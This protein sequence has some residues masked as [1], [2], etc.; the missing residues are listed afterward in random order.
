MNTQNESM[1]ESMTMVRK[2]ARGELSVKARLGYVVLL[3][4]SS[5]MT[6]GLVS[7]WLTEAWLPLRTHLAFG[8]MSLIGI[9]WAALATWALTTRRVLFARDRVMAGRMS[10]A[11]TALFLAGSIAALL[12][13]G[14]AAAL[15]AAVTGAVMLVIALRV[16]AGARRR[17]DALASQRAELENQLAR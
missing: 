8:A 10:V 11:F 15:G 7:L 13:T 9:A 6:V 16:L 4:A 5:A 17:F 3:L 14:K 2:L 12:M 1:A